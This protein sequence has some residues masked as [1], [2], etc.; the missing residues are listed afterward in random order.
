MAT[1]SVTGIT[2][3]T[4]NVCI[5]LANASVGDAI[6]IKSGVTGESASD[7]IAVVG[8]SVQATAPSGYTWY[9]T[10]YGRENRGLMIRSFTP[11]SAKWASTTGD[12][13]SVTLDST[14][15]AN[16]IANTTSSAGLIR[17]GQT[18][19]GGW[20]AGMSVGEI[21]SR[22]ASSTT[23]HLHP[24]SPYYNSG[25]YP[26]NETNF[27]A[28]TNGAK[29]MY[30]TYENYIAQMLP[31]MKGSKSGVFS[32][33]CG[34]KNTKELATNN[35]T[36]EYSFPAA[37]YCHTFKVGSENANHWWLPD[38]YE[39]AVMMSD[40]S[41]EACQYAH[42]IIGG[43]TARAA[44]RWSS[45]R[46]HSTNAWSFNPAGF[47]YRDYFFYGYTVVPVTLLPYV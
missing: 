33:R 3:T 5:P 41:F 8:S 11:S 24:N 31:I 9:G 28:D 39:L 26:M 1:Q 16:V 4:K 19:H 7:F 10:V 29:T 47:S 45:V 23:T 43:N 35:S 32:K 27:N 13:I 38:M 12:S 46:Y 40:H 25:N 20:A 17:N 15:H 37:S 14:K 22:N 21:I 18:A 36:N 44:Y 34:K 2:T 6:A 30:G 42:S